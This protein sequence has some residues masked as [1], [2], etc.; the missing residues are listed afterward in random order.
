MRYYGKL[1]FQNASFQMDKLVQFLTSN[2]GG[3]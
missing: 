3:G 2:F 1:G